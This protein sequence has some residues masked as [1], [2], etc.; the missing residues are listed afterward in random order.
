[1]QSGDFKLS[2]NTSEGEFGELVLAEL[3]SQSRFGLSPLL[4]W[5][6][7]SFFL[8]KILEISL[9]R[10]F[11]YEASQMTIQQTFENMIASL[12]SN[13]MI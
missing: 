13:F 3:S 5:S 8:A 4:D 10:S 9:F 12:N 2:W 6:L 11:G 7:K 1:M